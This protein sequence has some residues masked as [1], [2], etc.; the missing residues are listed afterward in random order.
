MHR[1]TSWRRMQ[2][3]R[4]E[5]SSTARGSRGARTA[6]VRVLALRGKPLV[7]VEDAAAKGCPGMEDRNL[8]AAAGKDAAMDAVVKWTGEK[9]LPA[10]PWRPTVP[11]RIDKLGQC[12]PT[13]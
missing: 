12:P 2:Y 10:R 9:P 5:M 13:R 4:V 7:K 11:E 1:I 6:P 3:T 8:R